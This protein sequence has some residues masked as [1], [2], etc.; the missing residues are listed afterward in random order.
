MYASASGITGY[1]MIEEDHTDIGSPIHHSIDSIG[2]MTNRH[3][4]IERQRDSHVRHDSSICGCG[5]SN[6]PVDVNYDIITMKPSISM[7][8]DISI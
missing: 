1:D 7:H 5:L 6:A 3:I 2:A 4:E 8:C